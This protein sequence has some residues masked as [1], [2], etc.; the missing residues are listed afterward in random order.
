MKAYQKYHRI[1]K[2]LAVFTPI[3]RN[4]AVPSLEQRVKNSEIDFSES[5]QNGASTLCSSCVWI[6][7]EGVRNLQRLRLVSTASYP[8]G[9]ANNLR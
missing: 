6:P 9:L 8:L 7:V 3:D 5:S 2:T 4:I 1:K